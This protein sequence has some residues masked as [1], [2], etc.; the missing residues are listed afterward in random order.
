MGAAAPT[1][2]ILATLHVEH[3]T[4]DGSIVAAAVEA[5]A[6]QLGLTTEQA[7]QLALAARSVAGAVYARGFDDPAEAALDLTML[8]IGHQAVV[9]IDDLG[10]P[11]NAAAE[12]AL[13]L[14]VIE[15]A[16]QGGWI[17]SIA[18]E[19]RGREGNR[20]VLVRHLDPGADLRDAAGGAPAPDADAAA[21]DPLA[22]DAALVDRMGEPEDAEA[23]CR[24]T[25]RTYGYSYQHDEYYQPER[26]AAMIASGLQASFVVASDDGEIVGHSAVLLEHPDDVVVEGGRAMVDPRFRGHHLMGGARE[27]RDQWLLE[28]GVLALEGAAVT[29]HTRSQTDRAITSIQ[30]GF[31]PAIEFRGIAGTEAAHREAV[32]GGLFP[33]V[34][35]PPQH[36]ALPER[37]GEMIGEIYRLNDL[38]RTVMA[39]TRAPA[40]S[41]T[42]HLVLEVRGDLG[43]AVVTCSRIGADLGVEIR[44]RVAAVVRGGVDVVYA[45]VPLDRPAAP[46]AVDALNAE[47]FI[48]A[49]V[50]P[51]AHRGTDM[52]RY[53]WLGDTVVDPDEIHLRHPFGRTLLDYVL[54]QR[55]ELDGR[56]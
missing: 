28:H 33:V 55:A 49:G 20:T 42:S 54:A 15:R 32:A 17:D 26:L 2:H 27:L 5:G 23:I 13:D 47:G 10:L 19:S 38:P 40:P 6:I 9:R 14:D 4:G 46:W 44:E 52:V 18:H 56:S 25:W 43:H 39:A 45:D 21:A 8:R 16:L 31:L 11:F 35:I 37:D 29:A 22:A 36:V 48:F 53:Q 3:S 34:P 51:L 50:L 1:E 24:L 30:L 12:D 41:S 7:S